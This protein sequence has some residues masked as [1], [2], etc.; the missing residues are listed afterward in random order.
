[1]VEWSSEEQRLASLCREL[2][3]IHE[4][5]RADLNEDDVAYIKGVDKLSRRLSVAGR[6]LIFVGMDPLSYTA[7]VLALAASHQLQVI[8]IGHTALHGAYDRFESASKYHS[9]L[10]RFRG[11]IDEESW[12]L[13]HNLM[14]HGNTNIFGR[15]GDLHV[16]FARWSP[17]V[18]FHGYHRLQLLFSAS[19]PLY[20]WMGM[21]LHSAGVLDLYTRT[22]A[23]SVVVRDKSLRTI[24]T[25]HHKA[26]RKIVPYKLK[27]YVVFPALAGPLFFKVL[28]GNW[29]ADGARDLYTA[30]IMHC[31]HIGEDVHHY[32]AS[33]QAR[34]RGQWYAMQIEATNN[35]EVP[36]WMSV[37]CGGLD[38]HI[39]HHLFPRL[40][41]NRLREIAPQVRAVCERHQVRYRTGSWPKTLAKSLR[42]LAR[43]SRPL[44]NT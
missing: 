1:M 9:K 4:R 26:L 39:E 32:D 18:P 5:V 3:A 36:H 23:E 14:H 34:S 38:F 15:D 19:Y 10:F 17:K 37:L 11:E 24:W 44:E 31:N 20:W 27:N 25:A 7:G 12:R 40:P 13:A 35:F 29:L 16:G 41:P 30:A 28:V 2:D 22:R 8:E 42:M 6:V 43:M 33:A 21:S